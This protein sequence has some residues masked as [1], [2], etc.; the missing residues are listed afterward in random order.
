MEPSK[1]TGK[2]NN[3]NQRKPNKTIECMYFVHRAPHSFAVSGF[4]VFISYRTLNEL[5]SAGI[6]H[7][8]AGLLINRLE[9]TTMTMCRYHTHIYTP[10]V[11]ST[12]F[13]Y[14][15]CMRRKLLKLSPRAFVVKHG[16]LLLNSCLSLL[17]FR[18][19]VWKM[20]FW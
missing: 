19:T 4:L 2:P 18:E 14:Y 3:N 7:L 15:L 12:Y 11:R 13:V 1:N 8:H 17:S 9:Q 16:L 6:K 20:P 10:D 5:V